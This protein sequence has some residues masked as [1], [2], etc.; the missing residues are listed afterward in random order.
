MAP[1]R[2][3]EALARRARHPA[4]KPRS[5]KRLPKPSP[6]DGPERGYRAALRRLNKDLIGI[7]RVF[8]AAPFERA[9]EARQDADDLTAF[10]ELDF[11]T[12]RVRLLR[13]IRAR[14]PEVAET[15]TGRVGR[16]NEREIARVMGI[17]VLR[18][19]PELVQALDRLLDENVN[20]ITSIADR[21]HGDVVETVR[22]A[23]RRG[24]R[25]ETLASDL[26]ER[27]GVSQSRAELIAEDQ[28]LTAN[29]DL[30]RLRHEAAGISRYV[31][32]TSLDEKVRPMHAALEGQ[33][34]SWDAPPIVNENGDRRHP[35]GDIRC[36]CQAIPVL[37]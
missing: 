15:F 31:W 3:A 28:T 29:A 17:N 22:D 19:S 21:L 36:R 26:V 18:E 25:V 1:D 13:L 32:S 37:D 2:I 23:V 27:Y 8:L 4:G 11:G 9:R 7:V 24:A 16:W 34:F 30:T 20:L 14:A 12:L 5:P 35:G 6:P 33:I 10:R